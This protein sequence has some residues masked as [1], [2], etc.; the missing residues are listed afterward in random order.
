[1]R[2]WKNHHENRTYLDTGHRLTSALR[3][4]FDN[5]SLLYK[6]S[7]AIDK[8]IAF[9]YQKDSLLPDRTYTRD[10]VLQHLSRAD[11]RTAQAAGLIRSFYLKHERQSHTIRLQIPAA[12]AV[13]DGRPW[14]LIANELHFTWD[15]EELDA[16][17]NLRPTHPGCL[18]L[19][20]RLLVWQRLR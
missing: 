6:W 4:L 17:V 11:D 3:H 5:S 16:L 8:T 18:P 15:T 14:L 12:E 1:M 13:F 10:E 20:K 2:N 19:P 7:L 9:L